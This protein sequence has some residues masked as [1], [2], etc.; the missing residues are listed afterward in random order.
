MKSILKMTGID[1]DRVWLRWI[2]ASEGALF[3]ETVKEMT[4]ALKT[5]GPNPMK[6]PWRMWQDIKGEWK[7][8]TINAPFGEQ[9]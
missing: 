4:Q 5:K 7:P 3:R 6:T 2:S 9:R 1:E 8:K